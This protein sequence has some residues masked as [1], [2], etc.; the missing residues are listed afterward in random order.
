MPISFQGNRY[1]YCGCMGGNSTE[2]DKSRTEDRCSVVISRTTYA[3]RGSRTLDLQTL[4]QARKPLGS[5]YCDH[6]INNFK[7]PEKIITKYK[8]LSQ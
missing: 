7:N 5:L 4:Y 8:A 2:N 3:A 1:V 6:N